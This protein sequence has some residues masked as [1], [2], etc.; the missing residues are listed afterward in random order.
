VARR[1][2]TL[3]DVLARYGGAYSRAQLYELTR[4]SLVPHRKLQGGRP[5]LFI[6]EELDAFDDG[7]S[8]EI[9]K[10]P[11]GGRVVRPIGGQA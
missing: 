11:R 5:L 8:L 10:T 3:D 7:A 6:E 1:Y 2:L 4:R 9:V